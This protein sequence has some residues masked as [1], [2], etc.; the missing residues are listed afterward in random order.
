MPTATM[1]RNRRQAPTTTTTPQTTGQV[2]LPD[3]LVA[4][5]TNGATAAPTTAVR[6][7]AKKAP[8]KRTAAKKM[9]AKTAAE[10][11]PTQKTSVRK[12]VTRRRQLDYTAAQLVAALEAAWAAIRANHK[13]VPAVIIVIGS[14][15]TTRQSKYGHYATNRWQSGKNRLSEV[16]ISGEGLR[17]PAAEV[18]TTLLHEAAHGLADAR[19]IKD[20][21]RQGRWHNQKFA[22]LAAELGLDT[23]KDPR[24][25]WSP[26]TLRA[27]PAKSYADVLKTVSQAL[28]AYRHPEVKEPGKK[29]NNALACSCQCPRR[30]RVAKAVLDE[31]SITCDICDQHFEPDND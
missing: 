12:P 5:G 23:T 18:F 6:T 31:G 14:G 17:R 30:I 7:T 22:A 20:T 1:T 15:T 25:G 26:C 27:E 2:P 28:S 9:A 4:A 21:S 16:L 13:D 10:K 29:S 3:D 8:A 24:I 11:S 19:G